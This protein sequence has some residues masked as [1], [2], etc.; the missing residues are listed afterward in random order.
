MEF[1]WETWSEL[2]RSDPEAFEQRRK[3]AIEALI[4]AAPEHRRQRLR[5][6]QCRIDLERR[7][8][9]NPLGACIRLSNLM[10]ESFGELQEALKAL[11]ERV[12]EVSTALPAKAA[13]SAEIV[14]FPA[15][16]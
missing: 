8:S 13:R 16:R 3:Q 9:S 5:A 6:L 10:W 7:R 4:A 11:T 12:P 14:P 15:R 2:A 1:D